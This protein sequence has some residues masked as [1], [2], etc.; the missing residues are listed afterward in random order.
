M[1]QRI[2]AGPE[3]IPEPKLCKFCG[4]RFYQD[5]LE[6]A[7]TFR[8]RVFCSRICVSRYTADKRVNEKGNSSRFRYWVDQEISN[9]SIWKK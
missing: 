1:S 2:K 4:E 6:S 7:Y 5:A 3:Y 9:K 8:K